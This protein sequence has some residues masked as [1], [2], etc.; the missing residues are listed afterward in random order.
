MNTK[1]LFN[2]GW[3]FAKTGLE[4]ADWA[5]LPF[6]P[7]DLPHDWLIWDTQNLY[8]NGIGW[9]RKTF[10]HTKSDNQFLL[11]FDGVYMDSAVYVNGRFVGEWKYGYTSFE[12]EITDALADGEN[13]VVVKVVF[14][15]PNSRW[16]SGAGIYR[17]V[18]L[19]E[20]ESTRI[21]TD[22]TYV[23]T[24]RDGD[25]WTVEIDTELHVD[26]VVRVS[27]AILRDGETIAAA[28]DVVEGAGA[29]VTDHQ[30]MTIE[31]PRLWSPEDPHLYRLETEVSRLSGDV[32][33]SVAQNLGFREL[34]F[35]PD[36]GLELNG[37]PYKL[38]GVCE[39]HDL[40]A[41]GAAFNTA[42][43]RRRFTILK[44][45]GVNAVRTSHNPPA[46]E[47]MDLADR[48]GLLVFSEAFDMWERPKNRFDYARFFPEWSERDVTGWIRR[49]RNH[50]SLLMWS[51][52]NEIY[53]T[54]ADA[55]GQETTRRLA[56]LV[57][58][59]D[60]RGNARITIGSNYMPWENAQKCA[61]IVKLA[62][63]NYA[64]RY[65]R[66]HHEEHPDWIIYGSET[67]S[68]VQSRGIYHFPFSQS[69]LADDDEQCSSLGNSPVSYGAKSAEFCILTERDTPFSAGQFLW[70]GFDYIGEPTPYHTKS[71]YYGQ[72]DTATF[73][74]DAYYLYQAEWT[75][76]RIAP[77]VHLLPYWDW[78]PGQ[79]IDVRVFSN[80]PRIELRHNGATVGTLDIDH[81]HGSQLTG[82]WQIPYAP[83]E[84][85]AI[86]Y[87]T[88]GR[89][90]ATE[91]KRSFGDPRRIRLL[92]DKPGLDAD[93]TDLVFV[94]V[95]VEDENGDPVENAVNRVQVR[96]SGAGRLVGLDNGDSTDFD[97]Y[98][99]T[100]RRLFSGR[101]MAMVAS[102][103]EPGTVRI[104]VSSDGLMAACLEFE[105]LPVSAD[106][107]AGVSAYMENRD[108]PVILGESGEIPLRKIEL[109]CD[110]GLTMD[111]TCKVAIVRAQLYPVDTSYREVEWSIVNDAGIPSNL[112]AVKA[113]DLE[114]RLTALGD[115]AFRLRCMSRNGGGRIRLISQLE[116]R[117]TGL[118]IA[119][120]DPYAFVSAGLYDRSKGEVSNGND[121]GVATARES[122]TQVGVSGIDF[123]TYG[124]D[125][126][127]MPIF[128]LT[129]DPYPMQ[130]WEG[131]PDDE[132]ATLLADV[133]YQ[134]PPRW[135]IYQEE[136]YRLS[137]RLR[138]VTTI[139]FV[140]HGKVHLKGFTFQR[141]DRAY[142]ENRAADTD[143]IYGDTFTLADGRVEEI[144]NNVSLDFDGMDFGTGG[145]TRI[146]I[147]GRSPIDR[148]TIHIRFSGPEGDVNQIVDFT[149]SDGY[150]ERT[151]DLERVSGL[152]KVTFL[153]LPGSRFDFESFRFLR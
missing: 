106:R 122:E 18:W 6:E 24:R 60:P 64:E 148:N 133:V 73:P 110:S 129:G 28:A 104:E 43:L 38:N 85:E 151:F 97:P 101:L 57:R 111:A 53:D 17:N 75:D 139:C 3:T 100:S 90:V 127:T 16:Y 41:L 128:A 47:W 56:G 144:G 59:H 116:F 30:V 124:S 83:G 55:R 153:F 65:Y 52:G 112:A 131:M 72:I 89:V 91:V 68:I 143:H 88:D 107:T 49:D 126:V 87:D 103:T 130:I 145:A 19:K 20:R 12:H 149:R 40:G 123:G 117:A 132:G 29:D 142:A 11:C 31:H 150:V 76:H 46:P 15:S 13:E 63:Y 98:K 35:D 23:S 146:A 152:C 114:A 34:V 115:G 77:M 62:G 61:D 134:K 109:S 84:I 113:D 102:T 105:A 141:P 54:H 26:G 45:M 82:W 48:M 96:V 69:I 80:A 2:D 108:L 93:G 140:L 121:R 37:C 32:V 5:P 8:E 137:K 22:G 36:R 66:T 14:Q 10:I 92:A 1:T 67:S 50:P 119:W 4:A 81:A 147:R 71:S 79:A 78:N 74:K 39:H 136:T 44:E 7:V 42:A 95:L 125:T 51:I 33:E 120:K 58:L 138:G 21:A 70:T 9:Y 99:G 118:G 27:H 86:A 25:T 135:N 94:T